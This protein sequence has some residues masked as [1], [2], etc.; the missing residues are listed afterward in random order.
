MLNRQLA[1]P[2]QTAKRERPYA[3][4]IVAVQDELTQR[5]ETGERV[6]LYHREVVLRQRQ[7]LHG[8]RQ[9]VRR[10]VLEA[11]C[12]AEYLFAYKNIE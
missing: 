8:L 4:D 6:A 3:R 9:L 5:P 1:Q 2:I 12:I 11:A 10:D 7:L